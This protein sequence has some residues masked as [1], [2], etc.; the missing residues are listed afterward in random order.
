MGLI[1]QLLSPLAAGAPRHGHHSLTLMKPETFMT[2]PRSWLRTC[3]EKRAT[4][5]VAPNFALDLAVR[6]NRQGS[7]LDLSPLR[8]IIVGSEAVRAETLSRF[9]QTFEPAS[10]RSTAFCPA[11]GL[12]EATLAVTIVRPDEVWKSIPRPVSAALPGEPGQLVSTGFPVDGTSVRIAG[13]AESVGP[14]EISS[15]S[16]VSRYIGAELQLTPDGYFVTGDVGLT[17]DGEL[18]VVGRGDEVI[19]VSGSNIYP[20]DIESEV[21]HPSIRRGCIA[22]V[23]APGGGL[24]I[25]VEPNGKP[26]EDEL[27]T[28][29][30]DIRR[31]VVTRTGCSPSTVAF[32]PRGALPKTPSGKFKRLAIGALLVANDEILARVDF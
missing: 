10:F 25:V 15:P 5:S 6:A 4:I 16:L 2:N 22:A 32:V 1:G 14:I 24:A 23:A 29:C 21:E 28:A 7:E 12:A 17:R 11:Y 9:A 30:R 13:P 18:Y 20:N 3:S 31:A 26:S 8:S 27:R 19:V